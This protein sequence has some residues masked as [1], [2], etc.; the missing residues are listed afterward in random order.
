MAVSLLVLEAEALSSGCDVE[1]QGLFSTPGRD[2]LVDVGSCIKG[3]GPK[4][5][6][7]TFCFLWPGCCCG[8]GIAGSVVTGFLGMP[9]FAPGFNDIEV[10]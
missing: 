5:R 4:G 8:T 9:G 2:S 7:D 6:L 1:V 3:R 10:I